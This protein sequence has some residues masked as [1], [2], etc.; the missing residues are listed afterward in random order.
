[1][2]DTGCGLDPL[3]ALIEANRV[4]QKVT[5]YATF[6]DL[7]GYCALSAA[8]VGRLVLAIAGVH[9][10]QAQ[11]WSDE[12]C[13]ALQVLEHCQDVG[14]DGRAGR[15]YLPTTDLAAHGAADADV[16]AITTSWPLRRTI[17]TQVDR[18][19]ALLAAGPPL[20]ARLSGWA[21]IAV[22]G[23]IAGGLATADQLEGIVYDVLVAPTSPSKARTAA[24]ALRLALRR[25]RA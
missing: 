20:V 4:D 14:E 16:L 17:A 3:L 6:D 13:A 9:D 23:Y 19:R 1:V 18:S 5:R 7:L 11:R 24:L 10:E 15:I 25:R 21:R 2:R 12:V 8:P 22:A